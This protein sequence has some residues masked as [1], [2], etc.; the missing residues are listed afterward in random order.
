[1]DWL[2]VSYMM[3]ITRYGSYLVPEVGEE[4]WGLAMFCGGGFGTGVLVDGDGR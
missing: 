3:N 2:D 4:A 1:M